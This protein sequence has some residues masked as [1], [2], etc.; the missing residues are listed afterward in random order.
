MYQKPNIY[1]EKQKPNT[2]NIWNFEITCPC[3]ACVKKA[4][5]TDMDRAYGSQDSVLSSSVGEF[6]RNSKLYWV[7]LF[8]VLLSVVCHVYPLTASIAVITPFKNALLSIPRSYLHKSKPSSLQFLCWN[9]FS[10]IDGI[11]NSC[12][13]FVQVKCRGSGCFWL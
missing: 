11:L 10:D 7:P 1:L 5:G 4:Q 8:S 6:T 9:L 13:F 2:I 12:L 3:W